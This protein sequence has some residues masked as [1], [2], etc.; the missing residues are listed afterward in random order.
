M[1]FT[2][3]YINRLIGKDPDARK[4][5]GQEEKE[6]TENELVGWHHWLSGH[7]FKQTLGD[8]E[9][10]GSLVCSSLWGSKELDLATAQQN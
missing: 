4:D 1:L 2:Y 5:W 9:G 3:H 10:Q 6:A 7:E 8:S